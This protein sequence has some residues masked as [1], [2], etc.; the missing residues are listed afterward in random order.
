MNNFLMV[1]LAQTFLNKNLKLIYKLRN[2]T[3]F[4]LQKWKFFANL[5]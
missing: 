5:I 1:I 2:L 4:V 3:C